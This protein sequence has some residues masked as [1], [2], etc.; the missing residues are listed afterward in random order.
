MEKQG[1]FEAVQDIFRD[2]FDDEE[3]FKLLDDEG[4]GPDKGV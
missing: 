1:I 4:D 3:L 2:N